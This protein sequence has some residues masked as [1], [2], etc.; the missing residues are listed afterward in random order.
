MSRPSHL[1]TRT[2][3]VVALGG[4]LG[5]LARWGLAQALPHTSGD[6]PAS[7]WIANTTGAVAI[8]ILVVVAARHTANRYLLPFLGVGFLGGYTTFSTYAVDVHTL[9]IAGQSG[10]AL[11]YLLG[12]LATGLPAAWAGLTFARAATGRRSPP[13]LP[14]AEPTT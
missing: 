7:T 9:L 3:L 6:I 14:P 10:R 4:A 8:G 12:T 13:E 5:S 2:I 11:T 1:E